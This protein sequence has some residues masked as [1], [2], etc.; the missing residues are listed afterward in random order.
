V[1]PT[2]NYANP[3]PEL[4][5]NYTPNT[6]VNHRIDAVLSNSFGFGGHNVTLAIKRFE[7]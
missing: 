6:A 7:E 5:L 2:I 3:D 1:P 4:D